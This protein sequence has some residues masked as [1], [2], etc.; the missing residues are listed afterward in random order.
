MTVAVSHFTL[1]D[2]FPDTPAGHVAFLEWVRDEVRLA[3]DAKRRR[4]AT[5]NSNANVKSLV[6]G[7][8]W[9]EAAARLS[10]MT[11]LSRKAVRNV[12][13]VVRS[14]LSVATVEQVDQVLGPAIEAIRTAYDDWHRGQLE[15]LLEEAVAADQIEKDETERRF[16]IEECGM[17]PNR[18]HAEGKIWAI[19]KQM[20]SDLARQA[21]EEKR[22][23]LERIVEQRCRQQLLA[24]GLS[25]EELIFGYRVRYIA[26]TDPRFAAHETAM[27]R[28]RA[29]KDAIWR[30][31]GA[32]PPEPDEREGKQPKRAGKSAEVNVA[33]PRL[34]TELAAED[35]ARFTAAVNQLV[36]NHLAIPRGKRQARPKANYEKEQREAELAVDWQ[37]AREAKV[38]KS[39]FAHDCGMT[40]RASNRMS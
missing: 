5:T 27:Q 36:E 38:A 34:R 6:N 30:A 4:S 32:R 22:A 10:A 25:D 37:R 13:R 2:R 19:E 21:F 31:M 39:K 3:A 17:P 9:A 33:C 1:L 11:E 15:T 24:A 28:L 18:T 40:L 12:S 14:K 29:G 23:E 8:P 7:I 35:M 20:Q 16:W 26:R